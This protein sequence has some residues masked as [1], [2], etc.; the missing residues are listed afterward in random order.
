ALALDDTFDRGAIH[1]FMISYEMARRTGTGDPEERA[2]R[3]F[4]RAMELS[5][6]TDAAP[7][8]A[9]AESICIPHQRREEFEGLLGEAL[10]I[11]TSQV[12]ENRL[13]N[14]MAQQ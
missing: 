9:L 1:T 12:T 14:V 3:H 6:G 13:A 2:R 7:L 10:R 11:D 8:L 4:A 5:R